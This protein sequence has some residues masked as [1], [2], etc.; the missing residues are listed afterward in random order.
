MMNRL[1]RV[2]PCLCVVLLFSAC[3]S[4]PGPV[5]DGDGLLINGIR[6]N[7]KTAEQFIRRFDHLRVGFVNYIEPRNVKLN[8]H[9]LTGDGVVFRLDNTGDTGAFHLA[10]VELA[11]EL[12]EKNGWDQAQLQEENSAVGHLATVRIESLGMPVDA[13]PGQ[14]LPVRVV[15]VGDATSISGGYL[16]PTP[17]R[18][19][20]GRTVAVFKG[21]YLPLIPDPPRRGDRWLDENGVELPPGVRP[22]LEKRETAGRIGFILREGFVIVASVASDDLIA[23]TIDLPLERE[24]ID[25]MT[26]EVQQ[27]IYPLSAE[28]VPDVARELE[29]ELIAAGVQCRVRMDGPRKLVVTPLGVREL[30][31]RQILD[32]IENIKVTIRPRSNI[33]VMFDDELHRVVIYGPMARRFLIEGVNLVI[34]PLSEGRKDPQSGKLLEPLPS[35]FRVRCEVLE[36]AS[37][38]RSGLYGVPTPENATPDGHKGKVKLAWSRRNERDQ[39][40]AEGTDVLESADIS[41]ILRHL[42]TRGMGPNEVLGFCVRAKEAYAIAAELAFN[43]RKADVSSPLDP[44]GG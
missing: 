28:L 40:I 1:A 24:V 44:R 23:D 5:D 32:I 21:G 11:V 8:G 41:D 30:T 3:V 7:E 33:I 13:R 25:P 14:H 18:N 6:H 15:L 35:A 4:G 34:D 10:A 27:K 20:A 43:Y 26:N 19:S 36:R 38:G 2:L 37:R 42:W 29:S 9:D 16:Y 39:V 17:I 31:L 22:L 12:M